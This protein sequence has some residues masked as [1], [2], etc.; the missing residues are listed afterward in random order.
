MTQFQRDCFYWTTAAILLLSLRSAAQDAPHQSVCTKWA[1]L[2]NGYVIPI[3]SKCE[4]P[5][6]PQPQV[7]KKPGLFAFRR[8]T[9][10]PLRNPF[11]SK[12]FDLAFTSY[13]LADFADAAITHHRAGQTRYN[14]GAE[15]WEGNPELGAKPTNATLWKANGIEYGAI[16]GLGWLSARY[17]TLPFAWGSATY[18]TV[19]HGR[20]AYSW[21]NCQ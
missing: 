9:D 2:E 15:C 17:F 10:P 14:G 12:T 11:K 18:G 7:E 16:L 1:T 20:G 4:L 6:A 5:D 3:Q 19:L 8:W 21:R 13:L